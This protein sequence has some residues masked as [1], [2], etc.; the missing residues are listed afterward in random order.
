MKSSISAIRALST[1]PIARL[2]LAVVIWLVLLWIGS[3]LTPSIP[4]NTL[5]EGANCPVR[6][7]TARH[8]VEIGL[9]GALTWVL[10][11]WNV[12]L[13]FARDE[14][15]SARTV[16]ATRVLYRLSLLLTVMYLIMAITRLVQAG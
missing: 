14:S 11:S 15:S 3:W 6:T 1:R 13:A 9:A 2:V 8:L 7:S 12:S 4:C 16:L 5:I 10:I